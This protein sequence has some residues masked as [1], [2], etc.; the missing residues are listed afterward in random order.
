MKVAVYV[1]IL[2]ELQ[3]VITI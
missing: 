1:D 3:Y 2:V